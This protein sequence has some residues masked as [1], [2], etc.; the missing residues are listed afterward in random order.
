MLLE[1]LRSIHAHYL[2]LLFKNICKEAQ[3]RY[4]IIGLRGKPIQQFCCLEPYQVRRSG[5]KVLHIIDKGAKK[6]VSVVESTKETFLSSLKSPPSRQEREKMK[7]YQQLFPRLKYFS[8][9]CFPPLGTMLGTQIHCGAPIL[10][11]L[12]LS[13]GRTAS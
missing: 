6:T 12:Q 5:G 1:Y 13:E 2:L 4:D 11:R 8:T 7:I 10:P 9:G 3:C